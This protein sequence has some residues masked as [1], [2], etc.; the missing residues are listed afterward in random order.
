MSSKIEIR[1]ARRITLVGIEVVILCIIVAMW[2]KTKYSWDTY[3]LI[4][5]GVVTGIVIGSL[6]FIV[7]LFRYIF[8][9][10]FS[11]L[12]ATLAFQL[13]NGATDSIV[14]RWVTFGLVFIFSILLHKD[15][16]DFES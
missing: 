10:L 16:F 7:R 5:A 3:S 9:I 1:P 8:S 2:L 15:Y 6:F 11:L 4:L 13:A 14:A 12:W